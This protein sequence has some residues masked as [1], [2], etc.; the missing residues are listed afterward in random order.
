MTGLLRASKKNDH[1]QILNSTRRFIFAID[2][3]MEP[4]S[5][6]LPRLICFRRT[7]LPNSDARLPVS[8]LEP[9]KVKRS[10]FVSCHFSRCAS[11]SMGILLT[12]IQRGQRCDWPNGTWNWSFD[13]VRLQVQLL[14]TAEVLKIDRHLSPDI[15][16]G[17]GKTKKLL[18]ASS[19]SQT[20]LLRIWNLHK[21]RTCIWL[22]PEISR[23][24]VPPRLFSAAE[25]NISLR[26]SGNSEVKFQLLPRLTKNYMLHIR[27]LIA[28]DS[29]W[30]NLAGVG[31]I[32]FA[33]ASRWKEIVLTFPSFSTSGVI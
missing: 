26:V 19:L 18:R 25:E 17:W 23:G 3:G 31:L 20:A 10:D 9:E 7:R 15:V 4:C 21:S 14:K 32:P 16:V 8:W 1:L 2:S 29:S 24:M 33:N 28:C 30:Q 5:R 6:L 13:I 22:K 11:L 27:L 12:Q